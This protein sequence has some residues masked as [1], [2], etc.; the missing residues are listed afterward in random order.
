MK[1]V[2]LALAAV[3]AINAVSFANEPAHP[4]ATPAPAAKKKAKAAPAAEHHEEAA[5]E[6]HKTH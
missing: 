6:E 3:F 4:A 2:F 1:N 5:K